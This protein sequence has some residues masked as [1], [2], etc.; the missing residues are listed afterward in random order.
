[1]EITGWDVC[2]IVGSTNCHVMITLY[3][4]WLYTLPFCIWLISAASHTICNQ[5][6]PCKPRLHFPVLHWKCFCLVHVHLFPTCST[7][8]SCL[9]PCP[10]SSLLQ[11]Y[12]KWLQTDPSSDV[13]SPYRL[14][15]CSDLFGFSVCDVH[16]H[17]TSF[18]WLHWIHH[19]SCQC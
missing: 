7:F 5:L 15:V 4:R 11:S 2:F 18:H 16:L 12:M 6:K 19:L 9:S 14:S 1:M 13:V 17:I 8:F 3:R 10:H